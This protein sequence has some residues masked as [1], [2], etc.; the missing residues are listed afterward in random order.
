MIEEIEAMSLQELKLREL[1]RQH[2]ENKV[3]TL[4][5][6]LEILKTEE[7]EAAPIKY[8]ELSEKAAEDIF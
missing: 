5:L 8:P 4:G 6:L 7:K 1:I 3:V 2:G